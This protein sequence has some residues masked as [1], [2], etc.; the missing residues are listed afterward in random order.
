MKNIDYIGVMCALL[1]LKQPLSRFF[2]TNISDPGIPLAG[3]IEFTN[4]NPCSALNG[5]RIVYLPLYLPASSERYAVADEDLLREYVE[6]LKVVRPDFDESWIEDWFVFRDEY[7]Q[8]I[9]E[10]GFTKYI[11]PIASSLPGL[12]VTDSSQLHP[13]DRTV[14]NSINLGYRAATL[15][16]ERV[17]ARGGAS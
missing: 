15:A 3:I 8:P 4:L 12:F 5:S 13:E 9:C 11:P 1:R 14:S 10:V 16:R 7:A 17:S 6:Y 2:W